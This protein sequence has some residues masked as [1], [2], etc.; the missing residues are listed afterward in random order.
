MSRPPGFGLPIEQRFQKY[1]IP[2]PNSG[3]WL[4]CGS[5][6]K[7][8]YGRLYG[9]KKTIYKAHRV[10]WE[11]YKGPIPEG[12]NVLHKCDTPS[13]VNPR[14]LFLGTQI[15]NIHDCDRKGRNKG[16]FTEEQIKAIRSDNR[17]QREIAQEYGI[18]FQAV[19]LIKTRKRYARFV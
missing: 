18:T 14:H 10:S 13:C 19:S 9:K 7:F 11:I 8:G 5:S 12:L 1:I 2:E 6:Y 16:I 15:E 3:C 4:W 17:K